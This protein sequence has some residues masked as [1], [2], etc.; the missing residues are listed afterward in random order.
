M[1]ESAQPSAATAQPLE[2]ESLYELLSVE[3]S[4][5]LADVQAAA[6]KPDAAEALEQAATQALGQRGFAYELADAVANPADGQVLLTK[7]Q[8]L[9]QRIGSLMTRQ[10]RI[11]DQPLGPIALVPKVELLSHYRRMVEE[12]L[13]PAREMALSAQNPVM[14]RLTASLGP[15]RKALC[16]QALDQALSRALLNPPGVL[17]LLQATRDPE[18]KDIWRRCYQTAFVAMS[19]DV[20]AHELS[21]K[22]ELASETGVL[23]P[24]ALLADLAVLLK[25]SLYRNDAVRHPARSAQLARELGFGEETCAVIAEHHRFLA[26]LGGDHKADEE[27]EESRLPASA[28]PFA[29][30][31]LLVAGL[32]ISILDNPDKPGHDIEAIKGLSFLMAE[33]KVDRR[34]VTALT[35][36]YLSK[37]FALFVEKAGE[38][39]KLC[40]HDSVAEPI[41]WNILGERSPQKFICKY[42]N[43]AHRGSQMTMVSSSIKVVFEGKVLGKIGKGEYMSCRRLTE[44]LGKLYAEIA[45]LSIK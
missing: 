40:P 19:I 6:V 2:F 15:E 43:C 31:V 39:A 37:K 44:E 34:A 22:E 18:A 12:R 38:I 9:R 28:I 27:A 35:R 17:L 42:E 16:E 11:P 41:L 5:P 8:D 29:A 1:T 21:S 36:L 20:E 26:P 3:L 10:L 32:F 23:A 24:A 30:R 25:P 7:G 45:K 13:R 33:G 14:G 4:R